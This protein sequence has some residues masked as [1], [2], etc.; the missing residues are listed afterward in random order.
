MRSEIYSGIKKIFL[1]G[2]GILDDLSGCGSV[3]GFGD[4]GRRIDG[5]RRPG[6]LSGFLHNSGIAVGGNDVFRTHSDILGGFFREKGFQERCF[7]HGGKFSVACS[8]YS[9]HLC[10]G[11]AD[12][13]RKQDR[14]GVWNAVVCAVRYSASG[15]REN[16]CLQAGAEKVWIIEGGAGT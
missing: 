11:F 12:H 1:P 13:S 9:D 10:A 2:D 14:Y 5:W 15:V 16:I 8:E 7:D 6:I 4:M 3:S